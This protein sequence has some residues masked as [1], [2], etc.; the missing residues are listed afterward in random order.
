MWRSSVRRVA[1]LP[2]VAAAG[3]VVAPVALAPAPAALVQP[4]APGVNLLANPGAQAGAASARGWD[5]VTIPGWQILRGLPTVVRYGTPGFPPV[6]GPGEAGRRGQLFV[7]GLGGTAVLGQDVPLRNPRGGLLG[8]GTGFVLSGWLGGTNTSAAS[9]RVRFMSAAGR[10]LGTAVIGPAGGA[11]RRPR[12]AGRALRGV[13]PP[14]TV[15]A[16]VDLVL[17]TSASGADGSD[18]PRAGYN[19]AVAD[20]LRLS[21]RAAVRGPAPLRPPAARVPRYQHVFLFYFENQDFG[22]LIGDTRRAP[23]L[24]SLLRRGSLL[25]DFFAEEHPSDGNYLALAGGSTFGAPLDD[26]LEENPQYTIHARNIGDLLDAAHE[27]WKGYLQSADGPCDDTVHR[28]YWDDDLPLLYFADIRD[29]PAYCA[30]HVVPLESLT[31]DLASAAS[32]PAFSWIG[33]N[34]CADMEGCGIHAGDVFLRAELGAIMRSPAWR[35]QRSL[36]IIT[37]DEDN[38]DD[39]HP[40]QR[41]A[42]L[43]LG[44]SGVRRGYVSHVR[45]THYSLLRTIEA[46]LGLRTLTANDRYAKPLG[47]VFT[48][49]A[50]PAAVRPAAPPARA[51]LVRPA[52]PARAVARDRAVRSA[53]PALPARS[54]R[55][56]D[57]AP[58]ASADRTAFVVNSGSG[59]VTPI[60]LRTRRAGRPIRVGA[61]PAAIVAAP[62][63]GTLYVADAGSGTVTPIDARTLRAGRPIRVGGNPRSLA[64]TPDGRTLYVANSASGT[65]TPVSTVTGRAGPPIRVGRYPRAIAVSPDGS[66]AYVLDW[67]S[68]QVTPISTATDR[69]ARPIPVGGYPFAIGFTPDGSTAYVADYGSDTVT[70]ITVATGEPGPPIRVGQAPDALA[71][72]PAGTML[73][74]VNGDSETVTPVTVATGRPGRPIGVG[75]APADVAFAPSGATA[76]VVSAI[77]GTL[78]PIAVP[79]GRP[80]RPI[81]VGTYGYP[82]VVG[83]DPA[84]SLAVVLDTYAGRARL[85]DTGTGAVIA[86]IT[87]GGS[88]SAVAFG[89]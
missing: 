29:R 31:T 15:R 81:P 71:V 88:P 65:V 74:V 26:P 32:T 49:P 77:S 12:L 27:S 39:P 45:Y 69:P 16:E 6:G 46:A 87:V 30:A 82:L 9:A 58:A 37:V 78:T 57:P 51:K 10:V 28:S 61:D 43:V 14:G 20:G 8:A 85:I 40:P 89:V 68:A 47:D 24:N 7:G 66:V 21:V 18:G 80:A 41:V 19:W 84:G 44:S 36:V 70:P 13:L 2:A 67:G 62:D 3:L 64:I 83:L 1:V 86:K 35:T 63:G 56:A 52:R 17:A 11:G 25:D 53:R 34:D 73:Y 75:Y 4:G 38:Y 76:Y 72:N 42:T 23:Y 22:S 60:D 5:S 55:P 48:R 59:T 54:R 33:P 50:G 79:T